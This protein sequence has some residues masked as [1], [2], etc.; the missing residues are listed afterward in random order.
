M[1]LVHTALGVPLSFVLPALR[2]PP[3]WTK[4]AVKKNALV[5]DVKI[6]TG[7]KVLF[8]LVQLKSTDV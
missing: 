8:K 2:A 3:L 6:T 5:S 4:P 7:S 1:R